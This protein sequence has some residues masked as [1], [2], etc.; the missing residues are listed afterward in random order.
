MATGATSNYSF[1]YPLSTDPV[2]VSGDIEEL[3]QRLDVSIASIVQ[4]ESPSLK[5]DPVTITTVDETTIDSFA[6]GQFGGAEYLIKFD[7][8]S[9]SK[10]T[11]L[12]MIVSHY[13]SQVY[14]TQYSII[15]MGASPLQFTIT[16]SL[17]SPFIYVKAQIPDAD[18]DNVVVNITRTS[19]NI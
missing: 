11:I 14:S 1:P 10:S 4:S 8:D 17:S 2:N 6:L 7:Q 15:E 3:A 13:N 5:L 12:K 16:A 18:T 19:I 9:Q